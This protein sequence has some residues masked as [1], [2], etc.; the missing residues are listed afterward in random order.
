M[1]YR[2]VEVRR[3]REQPVAAVLARKQGEA[4]IKWLSFALTAGYHPETGEARPR[5]GD[6]KPLGYRTGALAKGLRLVSVGSDRTSARFKVMPPASRSML[7]EDRG[8][9]GGLSF[10]DRHDIITTRGRAAEPIAE[11]TAEYMRSLNKP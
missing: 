5:K 8:E 6:G 1:S 11:A 3:T 7:D 2:I 4:L 9:Y 10:I